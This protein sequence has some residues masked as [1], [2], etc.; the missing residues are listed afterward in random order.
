MHGSFDEPVSVTTTPQ[1]LATVKRRIVARTAAS[2][3]AGTDKT[4]FDSISLTSTSSMDETR[5]AIARVLQ[6]KLAHIQSQRLTAG[7]VRG[8]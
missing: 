5:N 3:V 1:Q 4:S 6:T 7:N 2:D 8:Q